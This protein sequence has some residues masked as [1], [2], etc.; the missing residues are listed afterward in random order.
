MRWQ[1]EAIILSVRPHGET[2]AIV[3]VLARRHGRC[4]GLV[5]GGRS[6]R[7]RPTLQAGNLVQAN[8]RARL[9]DHLGNFGIELATGYAARAM[10]HRQCLALITTMCFFVSFLPERDPHPSLFDAMAGVLAEMDGESWPP[11]YAHFELLLLQEM[12]FGLDLSECAATGTTDN[13][14]YVSPK[15]A[16][17]V[18][19][20]AGEPYKDKLLPLPRFVLHEG[21]PATLEEI[22]QSL[23]LTGYFLE[24]QLLEAAGAHLPQERDQIAAQILR[25]K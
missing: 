18:S 9:S 22:A 10:A 17:A 3:E 8:W 21:E 15:S 19:A 13:L 20:T 2:S 11:H 25:M 16:R 7:L 4:L 14:I 23:R 24:K 1:D 12:G 6:R 5:R